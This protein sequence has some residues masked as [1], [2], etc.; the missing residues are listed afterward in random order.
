MPSSSAWTSPEVFLSWQLDLFTESRVARL[1]TIAA[2]GAPHLVP[3]CYALVDGVIAVSIDEKPKRSVELARLANIRRD[4]RVSMLFDRYDDD[5]TKLAWVR[6]DG[7]AT[8][9]ECGA[10]WPE[11]LN[12]LRARYRQYVEMDL[13][14]RPIIRIEPEKVTGWRSTESPAGAEVR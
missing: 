6:I 9:S 5:W 7:R 12:A 8:V 3:V 13:E 14:S 4:S 1:G 11:A 10:I 2:S